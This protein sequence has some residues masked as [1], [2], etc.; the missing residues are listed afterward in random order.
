[1]EKR[2][3]V[4]GRK[5]DELM[6]EYAENGTLADIGFGIA[7]DKVFALVLEKGKIKEVKAGA[8]KEDKNTKK[9]RSKA[10]KK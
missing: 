4:A 3:Q 10:R 7:R 5:A 2:A 1:V 8:R 9:S 6:K